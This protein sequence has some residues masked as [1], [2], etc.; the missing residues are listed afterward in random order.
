MRKSY[1][2]RW[3]IEVDADSPLDAAQQ[4]AE[5]ARDPDSLAT[6]F[7]AR[8][9]LHYTVA[10]WR[11]FD[12]PHPTQKG[13]TPMRY[14][15]NATSDTQPAPALPFATVDR[16]PPPAATV[17]LTMTEADALVLR[18]LLS[19]HVCTGIGDAASAVRRV[20]DALW[21]GGVGNFEP[22]SR[23]AGA[24]VL[25]IDQRVRS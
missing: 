6:S 22:V 13:D 24:G 5:I 25:Q 2:V 1:T 21:T 15:P 8:E 3:V 10:G 7:Q 16:P 23:I 9:G 11:E 18:S 17:T 4:G 19:H 12:I 14:Q 20:A